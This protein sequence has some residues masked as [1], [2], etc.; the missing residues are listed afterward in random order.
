M[1]LRRFFVARHLYI[2]F[3]KISVQK[4]II[5]YNYQLV[6]NWQEL[7]QL[8]FVVQIL[9]IDIKRL[10]YFQIESISAINKN[11][12]VMSYPIYLGMIPKYFFN[13]KKLI[14]IFK[15][16]QHPTDISPSI[17][18]T[19]T[20]VLIVTLLFNIYCTTMRG[21]KGH[22]HGVWILCRNA[23]YF[24]HDIEKYVPAIS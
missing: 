13:G 2:F 20:Q 7:C 16:V 10:D 6:A 24:L 3:Y 12:I 18:C 14:N 15:I 4:I 1:D 5:A 23:F 11:I 8:P 9:L 17:S 21:L 22:H 19:S